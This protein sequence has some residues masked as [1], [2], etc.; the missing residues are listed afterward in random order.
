V[1]TMSGVDIVTPSGICLAHDLSLNSTP[2]PSLMVTG[3]NAT[4]KTSLFRVLSGLWHV[5]DLLMSTSFST[6]SCSRVWLVCL[7]SSA[8]AFPIYGFATV[9]FWLP[10]NGCDVACRCARKALQYS[11]AVELALLSQPQPLYPLQVAHSTR[12]QLSCC[13]VDLLGTYASTAS[14]VP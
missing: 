13:W 6:F 7:V 8:A 12:P 9:S 4:G 1:I 5:D 11:T 14:A 2:G 10:G 3:P